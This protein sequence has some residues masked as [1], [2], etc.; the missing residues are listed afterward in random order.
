MKK[1]MRRKEWMKFYERDAMISLFEKRAKEG[2]LIS[3]M[4]AFL[5][6]YQRIEP[7]DL[8]FDIIYMSNISDYDTVSTER[9]ME[10]AQYCQKD[11]WK[12]AVCFKSMQ[13]FYNEDES[14]KPIETDS[15]VQ[16]ENIRKSVKGEVKFALFQV[17]LLLYIQLIGISKLIS[18][19]IGYFT[20]AYVYT[21][22]VFFVFFLYKLSNILFYLSWHRKGKRQIEQGKF[23]K[24]KRNKA[25][26]WVCNTSAIVILL[27]L[28]T[29]IYDSMT[30]GHEALS[31]HLEPTEFPLKAEEIYH[32]PGVTWEYDSYSDESIFLKDT[33]YF[34][35]DVNETHESKVL[36]YETVNTK[37]PLIY[38]ICKSGMIRKLKKNGEN[39]KFFAN[40]TKESGMFGAEEVYQ[41]TTPEGKNRIQYLICYKNMI[42]QIFFEEEPSEMQKEIVKNSFT[43]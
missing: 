21:E 38:K 28:V 40:N 11:G 37:N 20:S 10:Q 13:V 15:V 29:G 39:I 1:T 32:V 24:M 7:K 9:Q 36:I 19:P 12:Q 33:H 25:Y 17:G 31:D 34:Q 5:W 27:S 18:D 35:T 6:T 14:P 23:P 43:E 8:Q 30:Y 2:W 26:T 3:K 16:F 4:G 22:F 41:Q 42:L